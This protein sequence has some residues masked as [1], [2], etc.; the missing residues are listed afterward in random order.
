MMAEDDKSPSLSGM[1]MPTVLGMAIGGGGTAGVTA[2]NADDTQVNA[3]TIQQCE[4]F[5]RHERRHATIEC[6]LNQRERTK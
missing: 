5:I 2:L 3:V 1:I 6:E 4:P